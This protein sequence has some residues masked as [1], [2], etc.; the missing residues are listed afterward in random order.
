MF[1]STHTV[2]QPL[3]R[4]QCGVF[5][6]TKVWPEPLPVSPHSTPAPGTADLHSLP[7]GW[8]FQKVTWVGAQCACVCLTSLSSHLLCCVYRKYVPFTVERVPL[9]RHTTTFSHSPAHVHL[10]CS[11]CLH[12]Q[13]LTGHLD[14][15]PSDACAPFVLSWPTGSCLPGLLL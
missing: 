4:S 8:L 7:A 5:P 3:P 13:K 6:L 14:Q 15:M 10:H 11:Q 9:H 2:L 12:R 1:S